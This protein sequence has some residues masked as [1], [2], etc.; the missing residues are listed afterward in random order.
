MS[1]AYIVAQ[2]RPD[3]TYVLDIFSEPTPTTRVDSPPAVFLQAEG[4]DYGE[5]VRSVISMARSFC[6]HR[7][8]MINEMIKRHEEF[9]HE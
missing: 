6:G 5:A 1:T 2:L 7:N 4:K 9:S 8:A 3:G